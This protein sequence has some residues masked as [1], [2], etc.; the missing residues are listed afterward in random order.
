MSNRMS[1]CMAGACMTS[2]GMCMMFEEVCV[3]SACV[4][5]VC[6]MSGRLPGV[7]RDS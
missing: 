1:D 7:G 2:D 4:I 5:C 6:M 3:M